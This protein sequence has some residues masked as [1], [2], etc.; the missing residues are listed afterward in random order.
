MAV[1]SFLW[2]LGFSL[3]IFMLFFYCRFPDFV[4]LYIDWWCIYESLMVL[5]LLQGV[6]NSWKSWKSTGI[7]MVLL[8]F[9]V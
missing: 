9:F 4:H 5:Q 8:E 7:S 3:L 1:S 6:Y 2:H